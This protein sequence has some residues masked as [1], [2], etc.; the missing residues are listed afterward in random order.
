MDARGS[1]IIHLISPARHNGT[2][3]GPTN[4]RIPRIA[5][6][7]GGKPRVCRCRCIH[8]GTRFRPRR[9]RRV[10]AVYLFI[11]LI[12]RDLID[13]ACVCNSVCCTYSID[14]EMKGRKGDAL[15]DVYIRSKLSARNQ[16]LYIPFE[17]ERGRDGLVELGALP[18]VSPPEAAELDS[19]F[20]VAQLA[21]PPL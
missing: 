19:V 14:D 10:R 16:E 13:G 12:H 3:Q 17:G 2:Q 8:A 21:M 9:K 4:F 11:H 7:S 1:L 15:A 6:A 5:Q 20:R 18:T